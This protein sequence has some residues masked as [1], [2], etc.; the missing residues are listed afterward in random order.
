MITKFGNSINSILD[1]P[2]KAILSLYS[3][4]YIKGTVKD[5]SVRVTGYPS[6]HKSASQ[7]K[8]DVDL[9]SRIIFS[10]YLVKE[11]RVYIAFLPSDRQHLNRTRKY[12]PARV[13]NLY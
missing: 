13:P 10:C 8:R 1:N 11:C 6:W 12:K 4:I 7:D 3:H 5:L 9:C 2:S